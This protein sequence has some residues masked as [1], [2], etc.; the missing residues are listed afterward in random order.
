M[1]SE[2]ERG[3]FEQRL[4]HFVCFYNEKEEASGKLFEGRLESPFRP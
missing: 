4:F 1:I 2:A 3:R